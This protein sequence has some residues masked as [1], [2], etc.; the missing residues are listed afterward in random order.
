MKKTNRA[1]KVDYVKPEIL[2]LGTVTPLVGA[3]EGP[4][5]S[6]S[7]DCA[8]YGSNASGPTGCEFG[9]GGYAG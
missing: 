6:A 9:E 3:C 8:P 1:K 4:G 5:N 2:D 7:D